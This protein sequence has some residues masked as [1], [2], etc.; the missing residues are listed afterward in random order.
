[1]L[2]LL[3]CRQLMLRARRLTNLRRH[4]NDVRGL[5]ALPALFKFP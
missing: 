1:L 5:A 2:A 3:S 4:L